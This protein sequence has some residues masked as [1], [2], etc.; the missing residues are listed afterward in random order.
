MESA[1]RRYSGSFRPSQQIA[2]PLFIVKDILEIIFIDIC[3]LISIIFG[4]ST[5]HGGFTYKMLYITLIFST[6]EIQ[7]VS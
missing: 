1:P 4:P 5:K 6:N 3:V 2:Y 7:F